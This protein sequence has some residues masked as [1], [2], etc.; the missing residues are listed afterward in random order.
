MTFSLVKKNYIL[1]A[2]FLTHNATLYLVTLFLFVLLLH[3]GW[4]EK[5]WDSRRHLLS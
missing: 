1:L 3:R 2:K 5:K 4:T